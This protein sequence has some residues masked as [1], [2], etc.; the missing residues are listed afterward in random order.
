MSVPFETDVVPFE[1][2]VVPFET[3]VAAP[4][5]LIIKESENRGLG[6][7]GETFSAARTTIST[8]ACIL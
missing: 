4:L 3:D 2:D 1:T 7:D 5:Q 6:L 8:L